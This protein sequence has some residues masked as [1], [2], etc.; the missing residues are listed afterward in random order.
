MD[1]LKI[2]R[3]KGIK[4]AENRRLSAF[5]VN[6]ICYDDYSATLNSLIV[7]VSEEKSVLMMKN[8]LHNHINFILIENQM[9][10]MKF[11]Y[12]VLG[13]LILKNLTLKKTVGMWVINHNNI[14]YLPSVYGIPHSCDEQTLHN[15]KEIRY[16]M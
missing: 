7:P 13:P 6:S 15:V 11:P 4:N 5:S 14:V 2:G 8:Q 9:V 16:M 3:E 10:T 1:I 12:E